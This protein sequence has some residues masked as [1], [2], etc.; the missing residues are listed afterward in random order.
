M[1]LTLSLGGSLCTGTAVSAQANAAPPEVRAASADL[2][3]DGKPEKIAISFSGEN[4][5]RFTLTV[6]SVKLVDKASSFAEESRGFEIVK[7]NS[8]AKAR[9]IAVRFIG[10]ND[11]EETRFF[12]WDGRAI[13]SVG[14]VP[15]ATE[16]TG[17]GSVYTGVWM[18]FWRCSQKFSFD[19]KTQTLTLVRQPA[20][21]VGTS[22]TVKRPFPIYLDHAAG[23]A[24]V[25][26]VA[27]GSKIQLLLFWS[28]ASRP[29]MTREE[30]AWYLIK[31]A[32]GLCGWARFDSFRGKVQ[33][34]PY[35]G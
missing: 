23:R 11:L 24:A 19:P 27:P 9:Q 16:I 33:E 17:N 2:N 6:N 13:R 15:S 25:A 1:P 22:T 21:Y 12:R 26:T 29:E 28:A 31:T 14:V 5:V 20:Y 18:G 8:A 4:P 32:S 35:A 10:P 7:I 34:L 3:G 30:N